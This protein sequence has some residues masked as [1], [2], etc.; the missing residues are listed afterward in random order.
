MTFLRLITNPLTEIQTTFGV[1][2]AGVKPRLAILISSDGFLEAASTCFRLGTLGLLISPST[3]ITAGP[4]TVATS[5]QSFSLRVAETPFPL[6]PISSTY[7]I[8]GRSS[9]AAMRGAVCWLYESELASPQIIRSYG[10]ILRMAAAST[11]AMT[12]ASAFSADASPIQ[13]TLLGPR[14]STSLR[15]CLTAGVP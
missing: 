7:V 12:C 1:K 11:L 5:V 6:A 2:S 9:S 10:P 3:L 13:N 14:E 15:D 8:A 4:C